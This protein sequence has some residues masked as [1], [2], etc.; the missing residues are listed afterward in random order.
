LLWEIS[1]KLH[2]P[3]IDGLGAL[4]ALLR[5]RAKYAD[6]ADAMGLCASGRSD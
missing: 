6:V 5:S 2:I 3:T 4:D 1:R